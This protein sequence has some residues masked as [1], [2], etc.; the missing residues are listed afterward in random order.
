MSAAKQ[1]VSAVKPHSLAGSS[2]TITPAECLGCAAST[3]SVVRLRKLNAICIACCY[4]L[5]V[6]TVSVSSYFIYKLWK[7]NKKMADLEQDIR[8][9][10]AHFNLL[11]VEEED[12]D[13]EVEETENDDDDDDES[14]VDGKKSAKNA[15]RR[16]SS[17][18]SII[19]STASDIIVSHASRALNKLKASS[20][21]RK[22]FAKEQDNFVVTAASPESQSRIASPTSYASESDLLSYRTPATSPDR[23]SISSMQRRREMLAHRAENVAEEASTALLNFDTTDKY[24]LASYEQ[25][26]VMCQKNEIELKQVKNLF[27]SFSG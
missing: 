13:Q 8:T 21:I 5:G 3:L 1:V 19:S 15:S 18:L 16:S 4:I 10:A 7:L 6:G 2:S 14:E 27:F 23:M 24:V 20:A 12:L 17:S 9:L 25:N 11:N 26:K 22:R